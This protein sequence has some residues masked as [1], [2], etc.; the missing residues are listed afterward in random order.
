MKKIILLALTVLALAGLRAQKPVAGV[1][2]PMNV[3]QYMSSNASSH[4]VPVVF[5]ARVSNLLPNTQYKYYVRAMRW[6]DTSSTTASGI[7][8]CLFIDSSGQW[9]NPGTSLSLNNVGQHDTLTTDIGGS[10]EGWFAFYRS[11]NAAFN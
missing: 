2:M 7:G 9:R 8:N 11:S 4:S 6:S 3:P 5:R 1:F 10:Y